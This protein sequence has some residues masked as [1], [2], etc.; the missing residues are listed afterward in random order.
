[1]FNLNYVGMIKWLLS[2]VLIIFLS[3]SALAQSG[4]DTLVKDESIDCE[5]VAQYSTSWIMYFYAVGE[6]DSASIVLD[7]WEAM[8]GLSEPVI[9]TRILFAIRN[10]MFSEDLYD[11]TIVDDM[12]NYMMRMDTSKP[13]GLY[14]NYREYFGYVSLRGDYDKFTQRVANE[15]LERI[16]Y[17]PA[18]L[19]F[20]ELYANVLPDAAKAIQKDT[21]YTNTSLRT[22][23]YQ[24]VDKYL[25]LPDVHFGFYTGI[26]IPFDNASLL[27]NHPLIGCQI[28]LRSQKMIYNLSFDVK[29]L[30]S[31]NEYTFLREGYTETTS[32]FAGIYFG[33]DIEREVIT[34]RKNKIN[35]L[36]GIGYDGFDAVKVNTEDDN[37]DNDV[38]HMISSLNTNFGLGFRH[39]LKNKTYIGLQG[40]YNFVNYSNPGG[41]N[42]AGNCLT[43][44]LSIG[45]FSNEKKSYYLNELRYIE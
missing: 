41:T 3:I 29:F 8:C 30:K 45:G 12:L 1:L 33:A 23:Y 9:R 14:R 4:P 6:Y 17:D 32:T 20:T 42:F 44:S 27:G 24:R 31:K 25:K 43:I 13:A 2:F 11:S 10:N 38:S 16:F 15:L 5:I 28:G 37:P 34:F 39:F 35:L 18:E 36:G 22:Y 26:W 21:T 19:L 7:N 40:K